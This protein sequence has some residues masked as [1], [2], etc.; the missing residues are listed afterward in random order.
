MH[1]ST[2]IRSVRKCS[3]T[4]HITRKCFAFRTQTLF[5]QSKTTLNHNACSYVFRYVYS[6]SD[7]S[8]TITPKR[9]S[10]GR[11]GSSSLGNQV[12]GSHNEGRRRVRHTELHIYFI[13]L[14]VTIIIKYILI[15]RR[16]IVPLQTFRMLQAHSKSP[17]THYLK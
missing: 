8:N 15:L 9:F 5:L 14:S 6:I 2:P 1:T 3:T 10:K 13:I 16:P 17:H 7:A 11:C 12:K 4:F